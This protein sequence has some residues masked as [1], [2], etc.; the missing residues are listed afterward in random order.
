MTFLL[1]TMKNLRHVVSTVAVARTADTSHPA[2]VAAADLEV[3]VGPA[4]ESDSHTARGMHELHDSARVE[5]TDLASPD[6]DGR[7][8]VVNLRIERRFQ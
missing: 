8:G 6:G 1:I 7:D 3:G 4:V 2:T 5:D